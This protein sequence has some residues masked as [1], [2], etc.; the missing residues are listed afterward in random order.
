MLG[1]DTSTQLEDCPAIPLGPVE[2]CALTISY[3]CGP[4]AERGLAVHVRTSHDGLTYDTEDWQSIEL[5][6][7]PNDR[8]QRTFTVDMGPRFAKVIVENLDS[9][10]A[11][12]DVAVSAA[13]SG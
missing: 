9:G 11:A 12:Q 4:Q 5:P 8:M 2:R 3:T 13:L 10:S 7:R 6:A 1:P